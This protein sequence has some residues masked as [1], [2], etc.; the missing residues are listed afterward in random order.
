[1]PSY[2]SNVFT[3]NKLLLTAL[4]LVLPLGKSTL[5]AQTIPAGNLLDEQLEIQSLVSDSAL[6]SPVN[7]PLSATAYDDFVAGDRTDP[8]WW[9]RR[10]IEPVRTFGRYGEIGILP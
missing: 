5:Y 7:R 9:N 2:R 6:F 1:M 8:R 4:F 3:L 10:L